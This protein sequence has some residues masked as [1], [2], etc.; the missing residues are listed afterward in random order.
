MS[1][2]FGG[3]VV[4]RVEFLL[5]AGHVEQAPLLLAELVLFDWLEA[6]RALKARWVILSG[7]VHDISA[8]CAN[9]RSESISSA[10]S[11]NILQSHFTVITRHITRQKM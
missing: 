10:L 7:R 5:R 3:G 1:T 8:R 11:C 6:L 4:L 2:F 9:V